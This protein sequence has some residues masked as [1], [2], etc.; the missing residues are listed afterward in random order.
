MSP[1]I[2]RNEEKPEMNSRTMEERQSGGSL[3]G[4]MMMLR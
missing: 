1:G 2:P 3:T 4:G